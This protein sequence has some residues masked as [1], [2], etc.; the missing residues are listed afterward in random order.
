LGKEMFFYGAVRNN[1]VF[2]TPEFIIEKVEEVNPDLLIMELE[3]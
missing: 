1:K 3:S 2:N